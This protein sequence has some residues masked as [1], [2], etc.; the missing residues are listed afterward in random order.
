MPVAKL[1][2]LGLYTELTQ[3][4]TF[5]DR[6]WCGDVYSWWNGEEA[7]QLSAEEVRR[8]RKI[9][10][11]FGDRFILPLT[12]AFVTAT[13]W[14][15]IDHQEQNTLSQRWCWSISSRTWSTR[16]PTWVWWTRI[17]HQ[18]RCLCQRPASH[19]ANDGASTVCSWIPVGSRGSTSS[20]WFAI[21]R[22]SSGRNE[23]GMLEHPVL[24]VMASSSLLQQEKL[25][26]VVSCLAIWDFE[27]GLDQHV[28]ELMIIGEPSLH[29]WMDPNLTNLWEIAIPQYDTKHRIPAEQ[30]SGI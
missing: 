22:R 30:V 9:A 18:P 1:Q 20:K 19:C 29:L 6:W 12:P 26:S 23:V 17:D 3:L 8:L 28:I 15:V 13:R 16:N 7:L 25:W 5:R 2:C 10:A 24:R 21:C 14:R 27:N 11:E 4:T